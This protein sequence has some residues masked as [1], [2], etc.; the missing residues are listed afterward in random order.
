MTNLIINDIPVILPDDLDATLRF[1]NPYFTRTSSYSLDI[2]LPMPANYQVFGHINRLDVDKKKVMLSAKLLVDGKVLMNGSAVVMG[3]FDTSVKIQLVSGNAEF[4]IL[5]NSDIYIDELDLGVVEELPINLGMSF[6]SAENKQKY[7]GLVDNKEAVWLPVMYS[8][9]KLYNTVVFKYK[10]DSFNPFIAGCLQPYLLTV[11]CKIIEHFGYKVG[12]NY[13]ADT[14]MRNL[15][16]VNANGSSYSYINRALPHWTVS[17]F[18][19]EL[20]KFCGVVTVVDEIAKT[21][22]LVNINA[23]YSES[24][25]EYLDDIIRDFEVEVEE[26]SESKDVTTGNVG[27]QLQ[28]NDGYIQ[29]DSD[30]IKAAKLAKFTSYD[31]LKNQWSTMNESTR[32]RTLFFSKGRYYI[33]YTDKDNGNEQKLKEVNLFA[34]LIRDE[35]DNEVDVSLK[36]V[37]AKMVQYDIGQY[38]Y[39]EGADYDKKSLIVNVP[40]AAYTK[41]FFSDQT[42][43]IQDA[44]DGNN[45][46]LKEN[47][48]I[49]ELAIYDGEHQIKTDDYVGLYPFPFTD[50]SQTVPNQQDTFSEYSMSL[51]DLCEKSIGHQ[52]A[53]ITPIHT[54]IVH[55]IQFK[56]PWI[57]KLNRIYIINNKRYVAQKFEAKIT[58]KAMNPLIEGTFY[59]LDE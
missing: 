56:R 18:F 10:S 49:M 44:I 11:V 54:D 7:Y 58:N 59:R 30:I 39:S 52:I 46:N 45:D 27:Y 21:I 24:D 15:Y 26:D 14:W 35:D 36:I 50:Y 2:E 31:E 32:N 6:L 43:S 34:N 25:Y 12:D 37:P 29:L 20:E 4:N 40:Y 51:N 16:I 19:N 9:N 8:E 57:P 1:E 47:K 42:F 23:Y 53:E 38:T 28:S 3:I 33:N 17:E 55:T 41:E 22:S 13:I 48:D 5:T